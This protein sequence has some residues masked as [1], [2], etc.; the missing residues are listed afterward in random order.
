[1]PVYRKIFIIGCAALAIAGVPNYIE[2][3]REAAPDTDRQS[4]LSTGGSRQSASSSE[5]TPAAN[6]LAATGNQA[7]SSYVTGRKNAQISVDGSG[8][9]ATTFYLNG[10]PIPAVVD[11]GATFVAVNV[12]TAKRIGAVPSAADFRHEVRTANG[13]IRAARIAL[14]SIEIGGILVRDV[15]AFVLPDAALSA[16]LIGMSFMNRLASYKVENATLYMQN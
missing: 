10:R 7:P 14:D 1:M 2:T 16:T 6:M 13:T 3:A 5:D 11:T 9:F 4:P 8:H 15:N 12:S